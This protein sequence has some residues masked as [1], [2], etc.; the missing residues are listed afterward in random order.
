MILLDTNVVSEAIRP[1]SHQAVRKW[2]NTQ[3]PAVLFICA[4]V[5]AEIRFGI[6]RLGA[7]PRRERLEAVADRLEN[8]MF[9]GRIFPFDVSAATI[10]ARLMAQRQS[11]GKSIGIIDCMIAAIALAQRADIATRDQYGFADLGLTVIN[12]FDFKP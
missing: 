5:L 10:Y 7:G 9:R 11:R 3:P 2:L 1:K 4:P 6:E 8:E 12:P